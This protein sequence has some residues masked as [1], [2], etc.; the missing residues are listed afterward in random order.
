MK[1]KEFINQYREMREKKRE[2]YSRPVFEKLEFSVV[3][4]SYIP[5]LGPLKW[6]FGLKWEDHYKNK[7][8]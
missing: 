3:T 8:I 6:S 2:S 4:E 5:P 1:H 7:T